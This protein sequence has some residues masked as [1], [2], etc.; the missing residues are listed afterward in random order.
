MKLKARLLKNNSVRLTNIYSFYP[1]MMGYFLAEK[2]VFGLLAR[3]KKFYRS[4]HFDSLFRI[5]IILWM[6][7]CNKMIAFESPKIL[8]CLAFSI[9]G[10]F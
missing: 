1:G 9:R 7:L 3:I 10:Q 8:E 6:D 2:N 5:N 4:A